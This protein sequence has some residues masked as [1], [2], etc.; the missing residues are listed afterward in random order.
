MFIC[1]ILLGL[2]NGLDFCMVVLFQVYLSLWK[3][4]W[5]LWTVVYFAYLPSVSLLASLS[6]NLL[7]FAFVC[8]CNAIAFKSLIVDWC[9]KRDLCIVST[10]TIININLHLHLFARV[11]FGNWPIHHIVVSPSRFENHN[12][13]QVN[14]G[15]YH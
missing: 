1:L 3:K 14:F 7:S 12:T 15:L 5:V 4:K 11:L 8:H 2:F 9:Y 6:A 13:C 10:N